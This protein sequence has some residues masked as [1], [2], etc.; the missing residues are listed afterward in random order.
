MTV[1]TGSLTPST[2]Q[3][4]VL[5]GIEGSIRVLAAGSRADAF[6]LEQAEEA[7]NTGSS[8]D[9]LSTEL[10]DTHSEFDKQCGT[11]GLEDIFSCQSQIAPIALSVAR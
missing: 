2:Y 9:A 4:L 5:H 7:M 1:A 11:D 6:L 8:F 10:E 3:C